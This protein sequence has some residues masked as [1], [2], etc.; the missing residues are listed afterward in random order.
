MRKTAFIVSVIACLVTCG[1]AN[2]QPP[3]PPGGSCV[4]V[5]NSVTRIQVN[6]TI[7]TMQVAGEYNVA[8]GWSL[9]GVTVKAIYLDA[10]GQPTGSYITQ[11]TSAA[12]G[13]YSGTFMNMPQ[14]T[15]QFW[16]QATVYVMRTING[17][18]QNDSYTRFSGGDTPLVYSLYP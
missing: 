15:Q 16:I 7:R 12:N 8:Q 2:A 5:V 18:V 11:G 3:I 6:P 10:Q 17:V 14:T 4:V 1:A 9:V 13:S